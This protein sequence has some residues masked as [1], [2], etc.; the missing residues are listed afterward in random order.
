[1]IKYSGPLLLLA[2]LALCVS[3]T[4]FAFRLSGGV[5]R[6]YRI[7]PRAEESAFKLSDNPLLGYVY[8]ESFRSDS[9]DN[10][11]IFSYTNSHGLRDIE[12]STLKPQDMKRVIVLGDSVV[13]GQGVAKLKDTI[14][15]QLELLLRENGVEVLNFGTSG[16]C[17]LA[18]VELLKEKGLQFD[19]D[20]VLLVFVENDFTNSNSTF[21]RDLAYS[22]PKLAEELFLR[23]AFFRWLG[24][25]LNL[26]N[27]RDEFEVAD[28]FSHNSERV[29]VDNVR[30]GLA[31]LKE[32][33]EREGFETLIAVWPSFSDT[34]I[35]SSEDQFARANSAKK[36][37]IRPLRVELI[38]REYSIPTLRLHTHFQGHLLEKT[39]EFHMWKTPPSPNWSYTVGDGMHPSR[40]GAKVAARAL[41]PIL[42]E[43]LLPQKKQ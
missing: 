39:A 42:R 37:P 26:F 24:L 31:A 23:S 21:I 32:L 8:K 17:T 35:F 22:R 2:S 7:G 43:N 25:K 11:Q 30:R 5:T 14:P 9:P 20:F 4:E 41:A 33:S 10:H 18:E 1:M 27:F 40:R 3:L 34:E 28:P 36:L 15:H 16:Y 19:P 12:R 29:G 38:A 6:V 13:A